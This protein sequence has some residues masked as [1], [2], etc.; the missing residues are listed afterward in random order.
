METNGNY[1]I[2]AEDYLTRISLV[3]AERKHSGM[4]TIKAENVNGSDEA[5]VEIIVLGGGLFSST[6][7]RKKFILLI[8][9]YFKF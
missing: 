9:R 3:E 7:N 8:E 2:H 4:Y 1:S 6:T 5:E